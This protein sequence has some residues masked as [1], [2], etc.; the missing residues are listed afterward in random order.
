[1]WTHD[2]STQSRGEYERLGAKSLISSNR[3]IAV[4]TSGEILYVHNKDYETSN[5]QRN[6]MF[7]VYKRV[8][9]DL[10][11]PS[12]YDT[13]LVEL[14]SLGDEALFLDLGITVNVAADHTL[15][16]EPNSIYFTRS[17]RVRYM[18]N[19]CL[20]ICVYNLATRTI[21]RFPDLFLSN[22][23]VRDAQWFLPS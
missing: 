22:L 12:T 16:I 1:M 2:P 20:D 3:S 19:S 10:D 18:R 15:G 5:F 21:K 14:D 8:T 6:R 11:D 13:R 23:N 17:D 7:Y 9:K 4:T